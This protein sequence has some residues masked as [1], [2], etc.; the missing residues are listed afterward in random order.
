MGVGRVL[1]IGA[2]A[3]A[4]V[5][6]AGCG[7]SG[8]DDRLQEAEAET[9]APDPDSIRPGLP[10]SSNPDVPV[11]SIDPEREGEVVRVRVTPQGLT[12]ERDAAPPGQ[13]TVRAENEQPEPCALEVRSPAGRLWR[14]AP[15]AQGRSVGLTMA[16]SRSP[17]YVTCQLNEDRG[18]VA[19]DTA[20]FVVR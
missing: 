7:D 16:L 1:V 6:V 8:S 11:G 10:P 19:G 12:L 9:P 18:P 20:R 15:I 2:L 4:A 17:Y 14:S 5:G 3:W 13:I